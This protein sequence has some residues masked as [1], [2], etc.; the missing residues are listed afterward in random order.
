MDMSKI[1]SKLQEVID[2]LRQH[3]LESEASKTS[4]ANT[5]HKPKPKPKDEPKM[6][7][8]IEQAPPSN[9]EDFEEL[10]KLL[11][12][13]SWPLATPEFLIC[14]ATD[15]DKFERADGILAY[16]G[17]DLKGKKFLDLG[18]GEG[19]LVER[20]AAAGSAISVGYDKV[21][22]GSLAWESQNS[23]SL[24]TTEFEKVKSNGPY[25]FVVIYDVLDHAEDPVEVLTLAKSVL[26]DKGK[27]FVR[28]H[29]ICARHAT[30]QYKKINRAFIQLVFTEDELKSMGL[31]NDIK[32]KTFFPINDNNKWFGVAG[33][34]VKHHDSVKS[35]VEDFFRTS[36]LVSARLTRPPYNK[37]FPEYQ[38]QQVFNDYVLVKSEQG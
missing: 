16:I 33:L 23:G 30:H 32:Q 36:K 6:P 14:D 10:K 5:A 24:L 26:D 38:M 3:N 7:E 18:C 19:H 21:K 4:P 29:P 28:C 12:S 22:S 34:K 1:I 8:K 2:L 13:G 15:K 35:Q 37:S 31:E 9:T 25:D 11:N 20:V 17:Q 27:I